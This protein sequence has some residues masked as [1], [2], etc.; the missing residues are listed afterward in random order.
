MIKCVFFDVDGTL[1]SH[2]TGCVPESAVRAL[3][4]LREAGIQVVM[5]TGRHRLELEEL[6]MERLAFDGYVTLNG[7]IIYDNEWDLLREYPIAGEAK[8]CLI[9]LF[10]RRDIPLILVERDDIYIN[11]VNDYV[12]RVQKDIMSSIPRV[13]VYH[14]NDIFLAVAYV[15]GAAG[16]GFAAHLPG[17]RVT[18]WHS[19]AVDITPADGGK[20]R[21]I[22][23]YLEQNGILPEE[24]MAF[25]DSENDIEMLEFAGV[26]VAMGNADDEVKRAA[27]FV[28]DDIDEDGIWKALAELGVIGD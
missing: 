12:R 1:L 13:G 6:P 3:R 5:S 27:D 4:K 9:E 18:R 10:E 19:Q 22:A 21:G 15:D 25:G 17:L 8:D 23:Y 24:S 7:Q 2:R 16:D 28:T 26:G 14:G 20:V 11:Y